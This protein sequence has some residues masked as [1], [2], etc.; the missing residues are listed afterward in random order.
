MVGTQWLKYS[1]WYSQ[2]ASHERHQ[3]LALCLQAIAV[4]SLMANSALM[5]SDDHLTAGIWMTG[6]IM[7]LHSARFWWAFMSLKNSTALANTWT[8]LTGP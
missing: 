2:H 3:L 8:E 7:V 6:I 5:T 4:N 1:W